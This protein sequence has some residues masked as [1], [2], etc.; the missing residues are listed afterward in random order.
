MSTGKK[1]KP[2]KAAKS[3]STGRTRRPPIT[4]RQVLRAIQVLLSKNESVTLRK[5]VGLVGGSYTTIKDMLDRL[6]EQG[7]VA[8]NVGRERILRACLS[9]RAEQLESMM[10]W[11]EEVA[12]LLAAHG[13]A[14]PPL[15]YNL[16]PAR[17]GSIQWPYPGKDEHDEYVLVD[18]DG[19]DEAAPELPAPADERTAAPI[20]QYYEASH[21][22]G[23]WAVDSSEWAIGK[24]IPSSATMV[25]HLAAVLRL[26]VGI[27]PGSGYPLSRPNVVLPSVCQQRLCVSEHSTC[28]EPTQVDDCDTGIGAAR[29]SS[30]G[31]P[32]HAT[33]D[34]G[35]RRSP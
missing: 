3:K 12:S 29:G 5:L 18:Q 23:A 34:G 17:L 28:D 16:G 9:R 30:Q 14:P 8:A 33:P 24:G 21:V 22:D 26:D 7:V 31:A 6:A 11:A 2:R 15:P 10:T 25:G 4:E 13:E 35:G 32:P 27:R 1:S 20:W 19:T